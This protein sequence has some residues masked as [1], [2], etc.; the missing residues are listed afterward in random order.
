MQLKTNGVGGKSPAREPRPLDRA[1]TFLDPLL[2]ASRSCCDHDR[3]FRHDGGGA[4]WHDIRRYVY[5]RGARAG[6]IFFIDQTG[7]D[8]AGFYCSLLADPSA[9]NGIKETRINVSGV[10]DGNRVNFREGSRRLLV[11]V[12]LDRAAVGRRFS[13]VVPVQWRLLNGEPISNGIA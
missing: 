7:G 11:D 1:L 9:V 5:A 4:R 2:G 6:R 8:V 10:T 12:G 3:A 13:P